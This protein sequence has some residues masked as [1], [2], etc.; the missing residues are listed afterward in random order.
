MRSTEKF[1]VEAAERWSDDE[2][3]APARYLGHRAEL[4]QSL[5]PPLVPGDRVL[6]LACGDGGLALFLEPLGLSYL[7]VDAS[8]P[9][10]AAARARLGPE[11]K[12]ALADLDVYRPPA[13]V[14]ATTIFR[15]IYY[16]ADRAA[17]FR[18]TAE[19]TEKKLVFD[20]N[21]R[22]YRLAEVQAELEAAGFA[23]LDLHPFFVPQHVA[24]PGPLQRALLAAEHNRA[25]AHALLRVRFSYVCA[26]SRS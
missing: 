18:R 12:I 10:V 14:A 11:A 4:V 16:A 19:F 1:G 6:D 26:A 13:P 7:G 8:E 3:A 17:F 22:R 5:G 25:L 9:M 23:R 15:A 24:L 20:L 2:Y 21:P